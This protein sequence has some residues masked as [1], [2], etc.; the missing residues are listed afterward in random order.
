MIAYQKLAGLFLDGTNEVQLFEAGANTEIN[1]E[2]IICNIGTTSAAVSLAW[3]DRGHGDNAA[4]S[5]DW[6]VKDVE[7]GA[8]GNPLRVPVWLGSKET[9]RVKASVANVLAAT[10]GGVKKVFL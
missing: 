5:K 6:I 1:G 4:E 9:L 8:G 3:C 2:V 10:L 7:V